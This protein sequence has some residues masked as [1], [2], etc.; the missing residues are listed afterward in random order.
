MISIA[1]GSES[2]LKLECV[3]AAVDAVRLEA[4]VFGLA[5]IKSGVPNMPIGHVLAPCI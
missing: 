1:N 5:G 3:N 4:V 2:L